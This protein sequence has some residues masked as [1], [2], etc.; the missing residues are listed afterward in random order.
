VIERGHNSADIDDKWNALLVGHKLYVHRSWTGR[1]ISQAEFA[2]GPGGWQIVAAVEEGDRGSYRRHRDDYETA[3][4]IPGG[5]RAHLTRVSALSG[6]GTRPSIQPVIRHPW[7]R[8]R[9]APWAPLRH[10][11]RRPGRP[12]RTIMKC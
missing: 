8:S 9:S 10:H 11:A 2:R 3:L 4:Q 5:E 7:R 6:P 12:L 1:G